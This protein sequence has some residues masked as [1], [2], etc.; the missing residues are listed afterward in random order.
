MICV[1]KFAEKVT[2]EKNTTEDWGM[3]MHICDRVISSKDGSKDCLR[4]IIKRLNHQDPHVVMQAIV[5]SNR[6]NC[7][8]LPSSGFTS[9]HFTTHFRY[10]T[11]V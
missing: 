10:W 6:K 4:S 7:F 3:I 2:N 5:V 9:K 8:I 1:P 11:P